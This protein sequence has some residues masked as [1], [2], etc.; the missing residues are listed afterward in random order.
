MEVIDKILR[1]WSFRCHD[2]IVDMNNPI[3]LSILEEV[4]SEYNIDEKTTPRARKYF[5]QQKDQTAVEPEDKDDQIADIFSY[6][7]DESVLSK[8]EVFDKLAQYTLQYYSS[9][10]GDLK[11]VFPDVVN[12]INNWRRPEL[13]PE[14]ESNIGKEVETCIINYSNKVKNVNASDIADKG[15]GQDAIIGGKV[16]EIKSSKDNKINTQLQTTY[17]SADKFYAFAT[18]TSNKDIQVRVVYGKLLR[19]LSFGQEISSKTNVDEMGDTLEQQI[20][21]GLENLDFAS[22]IKTSLVQGPTDRE[23]SF[24]IGNKLKVRFVIYFEPTYG[25]SKSKKNNLEEEDYE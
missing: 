1:E 16:V 10:M 3:K 13:V 8:I 24:K 2:G 23:T 18:N 9:E 25:K 7:G 6:I 17:Y 19:E 11:I 15:R 21:T 22:M 12:T 5:Q 4:L 14:R 20:K